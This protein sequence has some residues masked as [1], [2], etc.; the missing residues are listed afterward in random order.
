MQSP[1]TVDAIAV[2]DP[3]RAQ[4]HAGAIAATDYFLFRLRGRTYALPPSAVELVVSMQP[5]VAIPTA[6]THVRGVMYLRGRVITVID[7][8]QLLTIDD[9]PES[10]D[11]AR[12]VVVAAPSPFAFVA[13]ATLGLAALA[14][15]ALARSAEDSPLVGGHLDDRGGGATL[16][17]P[18][19]V[20]DKLMALRGERQ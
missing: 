8:A 16:I 5:L 1:E 19:A 15:T 4:P 20:F 7:L 11:G 9:Q 10:R 18:R 17:D 2:R 6:G 3:D 13:D 12:V 14:D